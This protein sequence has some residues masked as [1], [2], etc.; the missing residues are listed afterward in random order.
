[1]L[2]FLLY[3]MKR[4]MILICLIAGDTNS[5]HW[6]KIMVARI[7]HCNLL[8]S[9][10]NVYISYGEILWDHRTIQISC[11]Y[12]YPLISAHT[13]AFL[14]CNNYCCVVGQKIILYFHYSFSV[15]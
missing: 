15:Y 7:L 3:H 10:F 5:N 6:V 4:Y 14:T 9:P 11:L 8:F 13:D 1:M 2:S 12:F